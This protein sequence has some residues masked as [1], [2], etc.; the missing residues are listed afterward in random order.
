[1]LYSIVNGKDDGGFEGLGF[2]GRHEGIS[3]DDDGI[4]DMDEMCRCAVDTDATGV[5]FAGDDIG[6]DTGAVGIIHYLHAF[7]GKDICR[8]HKGLIDSDRADIIEIGLRDLHPVDF[9]FKNLQQH[10]LII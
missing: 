7:S 3:H 1:M 5:P 9:G 2:F 4:A 6:L 8:F 10:H